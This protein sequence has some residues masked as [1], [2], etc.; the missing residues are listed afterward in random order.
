[1]VMCPGR[2]FCGVIALP[3]EVPQPLKVGKR[4]VDMRD[5]GTDSSLEL[6]L[7]ILLQRLAI[8]FLGRHFGRST[9]SPSHPFL[10][11]GDP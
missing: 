10:S 1:M 11:L 8:V 2:S 4:S 5:H 3:S 6:L 9:P 7:D